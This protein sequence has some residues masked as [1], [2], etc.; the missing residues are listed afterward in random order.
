MIPPIQIDSKDGHDVVVPVPDMV[1]EK[2]LRTIVFN[3][4]KE[5]PGKNFY[6]QNLIYTT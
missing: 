4:S 5:S 1:A 3:S 2:Y 6:Y